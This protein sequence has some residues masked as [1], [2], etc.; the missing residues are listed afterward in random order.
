MRRRVFLPLGSAVL[1]APLWLTLAFGTDWQ[2]HPA[3]G[4]PA[5]LLVVAAV[6]LGLIG[7]GSS[8]YDPT[9]LLFLA[10]VSAGTALVTNPFLAAVTRTPA[11]LFGPD[12][13]LLVGALALYMAAFSVASE[14]SSVGLGA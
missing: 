5:A 6:A 10:L 3:V 7:A 1:L 2:A 9:A 12:A 11:D 8:R 4:V 13:A 14:P